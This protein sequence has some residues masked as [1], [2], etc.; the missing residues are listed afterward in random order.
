MCLAVPA[1]IIQIEDGNAQIDLN[2][3][4]RRVSLYLTPEARLG[5]Y[6][7][8]HAGFAIKVLDQRAAR[9]TLELLKE[10]DATDQ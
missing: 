1:K 8:L 4:R 10:I 7:L 2:G 9:R 3:V 5:D 6:V